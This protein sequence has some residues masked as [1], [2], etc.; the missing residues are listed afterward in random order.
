MSHFYTSKFKLG[1]VHDY[2]Y[3]INMF[4][5]AYHLM[6]LLQIDLTANLLLSCQSHVSPELEYSTM[7]YE[8]FVE[9]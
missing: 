5:A 8:H 9:A 4:V 2:M 7:I 1:T 6:V 3:N